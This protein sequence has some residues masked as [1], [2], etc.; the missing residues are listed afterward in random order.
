MLV[1]KMGISNNVNDE[2]KC[3]MLLLKVCL[4]LELKE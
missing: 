2:T 1:G 4:E 3:R